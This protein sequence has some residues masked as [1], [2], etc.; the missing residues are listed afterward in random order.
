M[1]DDEGNIFVTETEQDFINAANPNVGE[2]YRNFC[3]E[4]LPSYISNITRS[5][6]IPV[7]PVKV[8]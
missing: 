5:Y 1:Y 3:V 4:C 2:E 7:K 8:E 6:L